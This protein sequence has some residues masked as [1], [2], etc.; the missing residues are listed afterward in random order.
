MAGRP[1]LDNEAI[2]KDRSFLG[3]PKGLLTICLRYLCNSFSYYGF[4]AIL[5]YYL[6]KEAPVGLGFDKTEAAQLLSL[7][8]ALVVICGVVG[9]YM[10]DR[11][12]GVRK[13]LRLMNI[14]APIPYMIL[15]IPG[16]GVIGYAVATGLLL[17]NSMIAGQSMNTLTAKLYQ[18][19][20]E[21][22]DSAFAY[23]YIIAN[24]GA[25]IPAVTGTIAIM[26]SYHAAFALC[27]AAS[28]VGSTIFLSTERRVFGTIAEEPAD[29]F[30]EATRKKAVFVLA[31][32]VAIIA[33]ILT[34][35][36]S[37]RIITIKQFANTVSSV[38]V[39]L[40]AIYLIYV[41]SSPKTKPE[42]K[43]RVLFIIP[44][45]IAYCF[46]NLV[47]Y[48]GNTVLS[49]YAETSVNMNFFGR[50]ITP[51][52]FVTLQSIFSI[53]LGSAISGLWA[54]L[55]KKQPSTPG[56]MGI[57][58]LC[59]G[60][61]IL[62]MVLPF[63]IYAP[64]VKVSPFWMIAFYFVMIIGEA[65]SY[66]AGTSAASQLAPAAFS[67]QM[68][69]IWGFSVTAGANLANL[70]SNFYHEGSEGVYFLGIGLSTALA[71]LILLFFE[72]RLA[73]GMGLNE[74]PAA[75]AA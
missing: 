66:P 34:Y 50:E 9:S 35:L 17:C 2:F 62:I 4:T 57:G 36:F 67:T 1:V 44:I 3:H 25:A 51:A 46:T 48:Q 5:I 45:F 7:Y 49:I 14:I 68:M 52:S 61:S 30:P 38:A 71:G 70:V 31:G 42:E 20:D 74:G 43:R 60:I 29:P 56:K 72:K 12:F 73:K 16:S 6:Y 27:A 69:T 10:A 24:I 26:F 22:R 41:I 55:G 33:A 53:L 59:Y 23:I 63:Q 65:V 64:G 13:A 21:R 47:S 28:V 19:G 11:V 39:F 32:I 18:Q 15:A 58:T 54:K 40:P 8:F 37:N 75:E